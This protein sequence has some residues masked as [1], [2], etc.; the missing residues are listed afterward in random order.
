LAGCPLDP[1]DLCR[2][3][4]LASIMTQHQIAALQRAGNY[5]SGSMPRFAR[6]MPLP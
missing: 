4:S 2:K 1:G 5:L 6:R 3:G